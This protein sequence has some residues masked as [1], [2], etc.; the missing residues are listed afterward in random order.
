MIPIPKSM[1]LAGGAFNGARG[2]LAVPDR[3]IHIPDLIIA[4]PLSTSIFSHG[5]NRPTQVRSRGFLANISWNSQGVFRENNFCQDGKWL[6]EWRSVGEGNA[7]LPLKAQIWCDTGSQMFALHFVKPGI[8]NIAVK[9]KDRLG[10][11]QTLIRTLWRLNVDILHST[12][13]TI[14]HGQLQV[15]LICAANN[16]IDAKELRAALTEE[17]SP[18][19]PD[20]YVDVVGES[21]EADIIA[22]RSHRDHIMRSVFISYS[23]LDRAFARRLFDFLTGSGVKCW[24]DEHE[25]VPGDKMHD[26]IGRGVDTN[27]RFIIILSKHSLASWWVDNELEEALAKERKLGSYIIIPID[28]DGAVFEALPKNSKCPQIR[29][30]YIGDFRD[31]TNEEAF[32][33]AGRQLLRAL[34]VSD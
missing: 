9:S 29:S 4:G 13:S 1:I 17:L 24:I 8:F 10:V 19:E 20:S 27:E 30:R 5:S 28:I 25:I 11:I 31:W 18:L 22:S 34:R 14:D 12:T 2:I 6:H 15:L 23:H 3:A 32:D 21:L 33:K 26:A 16:A 7:S